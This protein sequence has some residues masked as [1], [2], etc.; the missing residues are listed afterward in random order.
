MDYHQGMHSDAAK[1]RFLEELG[2]PW[3]AEEM[4]DAVPDC[5]YFVKDREGRYVAVNLALVQRC[6]CQKKSEL[7]GRTAR[8][9]FPPPLGESFTEQDHEVIRKSRPIRGQLELHLYPNGSRGW[10]LTWKEPIVSAGGETMGVSGISRDVTAA[11]DAARDLDQ[12]AR[13]LEHID[14]HLD[15][16]LRL[17]DLAK[18]V[19]LSPYQ[20]DQRIRNL[21][22]LSTAQYITRKRIELACHLLEKSQENITGIALECGYGDQSAF[23]R[24][25]RQSVGIT[26]GAFR[27]RRPESG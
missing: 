7:I 24:Q 26:P 13:V 2:R 3:L 17:N 10:C 16:P 27:D 22:D 25:F 18:E 12:V 9:V 5:V 15:S 4:F 23:T 21:F 14:K 1:K 20:L 19:G 6:G 11:P 8:E